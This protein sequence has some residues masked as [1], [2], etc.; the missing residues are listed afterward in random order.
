MGLSRNKVAVS[1]GAAG[2][3]PFYGD[4]GQHSTEV[5]WYDRS[6]KVENKNEKAQMTNHG[7][8]AQ[9]GIRCVLCSVQTSVI[10]LSGTNENPI[11]GCSSAGRAP[12]L[13]AGGQGFDSLHLHQIFGKPKIYLFTFHSSLFTESEWEGKAKR[14]DGKNRIPMSKERSVAQVVRARA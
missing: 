2:S 1:E 4:R 13:Q 8:E 6:S 9:D 10:Q 3:P 5:Q 11:W 12:A 7:Q 14:K